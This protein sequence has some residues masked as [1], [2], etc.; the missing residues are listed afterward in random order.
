MTTDSRPL[1]PPVAPSGTQWTLQAHDQEL[2]VVEVGGGIRSYARGGREV[3]YGYPVE[4]K[5]DAGRG[6]L[7]MPWPNRVRDGRFSFGGRDEQLALSE[8]ARDNASHG[9]V[10]W[11]NWRLVERSADSLVVA[12]TLL[13][14]QG[15]DWPLDLSCRYTLT[16]TGLVVEPSATNLG[17]EPAPFGF[18]AHPYLTAGEARVDD[19]QLTLPADTVLEVD[20]R[21]IPTGQASVPAELDFRAGRRIEG[22]QLDHAFTDLAGERWEITIAHGDRRVTLW[23]DGTAYPFAQV[24]T[25][26][27][28]PGDRARRT[29]IA[30]EP[31]TCPANALATGDSLIVLQPGERWG[32]PW[33][34]REDA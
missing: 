22:T 33:G 24:F 34:V 7:L 17:T 21:L 20:D 26:D 8:P 23:A 14:Q 12:H 10:R 29:G 16:E 3:L 15:W 6:Q 19:L 28:L 5:A 32:A 1:A 4:A 13:P 2:T 18:G 27:S 31:M 30:V 25:G 9:L 11:A